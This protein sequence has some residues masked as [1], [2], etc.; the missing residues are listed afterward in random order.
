MAEKLPCRYCKDEYGALNQ[1]RILRMKKNEGLYVDYIC[2][3]RVCIRV[4]LV[5]LKGT[6]SLIPRDYI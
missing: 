4:L 1:Y 3:I 2:V 6:E 5:E